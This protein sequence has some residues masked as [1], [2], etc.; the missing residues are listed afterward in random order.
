MKIFYVDN[1]LQ[2][3]RHYFRDKH[4]QINFKE[5]HKAIVGMDVNLSKAKKKSNKNTRKIRVKK[6]A[7]K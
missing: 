5:Q 6:L 4:H 2:S 7:S 1:I 3:R